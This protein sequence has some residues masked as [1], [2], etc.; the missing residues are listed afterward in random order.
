MSEQFCTLTMFYEYVW[1]LYLIQKRKTK[2]WK[3]K[4][5]SG[6]FS[7]Q[8][9]NGSYW[10]CLL[11]QGKNQSNFG[12][13]SLRA[14]KYTIQNLVLVT[15]LVIYEKNIS[16][17][18][19]ICSKFDSLNF[20]TFD[21]ELITF[22]LSIIRTQF[23]LIWAKLSNSFQATFV[24]KANLPLLTGNVDVKKLQL[25]IL[26]FN[27]HFKQKLCYIRHA[28]YSAMINSSLWSFAWNNVVWTAPGTWLE[29]QEVGFHSSCCF[30]SLL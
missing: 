28:T 12:T 29:L 26:C 19:I 27:F 11:L 17:W 23:N 25:V 1:L 22:H 20:W 2:F 14:T 16:H 7:R 21:I 5:W 4:F 6:F 30:L 13:N 3:A 9:T 10:H 24:R 18:R 15:S 8:T